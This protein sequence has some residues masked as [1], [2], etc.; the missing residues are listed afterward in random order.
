MNSGFSL[1]NSI[2]V[3][4]NRCKGDNEGMRVMRPCLSLER[5]SSQALF[6][7]GALTPSYYSSGDLS[8][9][10]LPSLFM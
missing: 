5:I 1:S 10:Y 2:S 4:S 7:P 9:Q 8:W 3:I 6:I